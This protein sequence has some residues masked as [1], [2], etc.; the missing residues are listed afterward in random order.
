MRRKAGVIA[1]KYSLKNKTE[2]TIAPQRPMGN[3]NAFPRINWLVIACLGLSWLAGCA[4]ETSKP[5]SSP[6]PAP[7]AAAPGVSAPKQEAPTPRPSGDPLEKA[8][9]T[10]PAPFEAEGWQSLFDGRTLT[11]WRETQF[12]GRGEIE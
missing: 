4:T 8:A 12:S 6:A 9:A 11:G 10:A 3:P 5:A 1:D 7:S 2:F